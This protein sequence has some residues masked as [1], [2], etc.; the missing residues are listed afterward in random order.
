LESRFHRRSG[1]RQIEKAQRSLV[2]LQ[3]SCHEMLPRA[4]R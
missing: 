4:A 3:F 2:G 1:N